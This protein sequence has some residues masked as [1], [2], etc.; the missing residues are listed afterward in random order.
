MG[1]SVIKTVSGTN[2]AY[3]TQLDEWAQ[4]AL[5]GPSTVIPEW[6]H[7]KTSSGFGVWVLTYH[8]NNDCTFHIIIELQINC[9]IGIPSLNV[10]FGI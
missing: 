7:N 8:N 5:N 6:A 1:K 3:P 10:I 9:Q 2:G 4:P